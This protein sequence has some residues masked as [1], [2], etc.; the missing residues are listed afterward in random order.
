M[1]WVIHGKVVFTIL[2]TFLLVLLRFPILILLH[3]LKQL[4]PSRCIKNALRFC[5]LILF[6]HGQ[7]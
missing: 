4:L 2:A 5:S 1:Q 6:N 3:L 7:L